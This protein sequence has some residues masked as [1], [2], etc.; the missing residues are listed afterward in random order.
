MEI[1]QE[2]YV[3]GGVTALAVVVLVVVYIVS[4][5]RF[6]LTRSEPS[7]KRPEWMRTTPPPETTA[8]TQASGNGI[9][10]YR[11][12]PGEQVAAPFTEQIEDILRASLG[13]DSVLAAMDV[14]LG[15][16]PDGSLEVWVDGE[17]YTDFDLIPNERLRQ[18]LRDAIEDWKKT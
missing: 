17:R 6:N 15:T 7:D 14:D 11:H 3:I 9:R 13:A 1:P 12:D 16:A 18:A 4:M 2:I 10:P 8:A 5:R